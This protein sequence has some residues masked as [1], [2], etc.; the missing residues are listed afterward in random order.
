MR[1]GT[2]GL[3]RSAL[4]PNDP[5]KYTYCD[6]RTFA[7]TARPRLPQ[8]RRPVRRR[9]GGGRHPAA[10]RDGRG[11]G[12]VAADL[13]DD[14]RID[15]FVANDMSANFLFRNL[16]GFRFEETAAESGVATNAAGGYQAGMGVACGDLDGDGR[17]DLA[18]TNF[19]GESTTF[20]RNLGGGLFADQTAAI[21]LAAPSRYLLGFGVAFLDANN[22]GR[23]DLATANGHVNDLRPNVPVSP[24]R[25][26]SCS[27]RRRAG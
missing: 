12:V 7:A 21:G 2:L 25:R 15:L 17:P 13:D 23:L 16:G 22:D 19:Y 27:A 26:S 3:R 9:D 6:P 24:C 20:Y 1:T 10:D 8:R 18:V 5:H 14:G 11:L 4:I